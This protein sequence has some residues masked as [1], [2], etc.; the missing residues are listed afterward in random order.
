MSGWQEGQNVRR[1]FL[2]DSF[3]IFH[4]RDRRD[5]EFEFH[6]HVF[7]KLIVFLKGSVRYNVEGRT[8]SLEPWDIL[9]IRDNEIHRPLIDSSS[10][11]ERIILWVHDSTLKQLSQKGMI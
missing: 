6:S 3:R 5:T 8:Y 7:H 1:G 10:E 2:Y 4:I 9:L 11:Y